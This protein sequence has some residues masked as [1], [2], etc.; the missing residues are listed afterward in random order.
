MENGIR[1]PR[2]AAALEHRIVRD[3][4]QPED[5]QSAEEGRATHSINSPD[6]VLFQIGLTLAIALWVALMANILVLATGA[7]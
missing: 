1:H 4:D 6:V 7:A 5:L 2:L 3:L